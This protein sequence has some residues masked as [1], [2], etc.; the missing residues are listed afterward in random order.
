MYAPSTCTEELSSS[1]AHDTCT[2]PD[3]QL[4][5]RTLD[6]VAAAVAVCSVMASDLADMIN[7]LLLHS[8]AK[9]HARTHTHCY[10]TV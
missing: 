2:E 4:V 1:G 5:T 6:G 3:V 7:V 8:F 9:H 10:E